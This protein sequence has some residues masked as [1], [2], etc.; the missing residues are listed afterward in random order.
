MKKYL[1]SEDGLES[2]QKVTELEAENL[3][4][5]ERIRSLEE[6]LA[7]E[8]NLFHLSDR[9]P[10]VMIS[11]TTLFDFEIS[12]EEREKKRELKLE[13]SIKIEKME[14]SEEYPLE[15]KIREELNQE[16]AEEQKRMI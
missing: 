15:K 8:E 4:M 14:I 5:A 10:L 1:E 12:K 7:M 6:Q 2:P 11:E 3:R 13:E 16:K 9:T